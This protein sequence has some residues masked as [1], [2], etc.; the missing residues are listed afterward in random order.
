MKSIRVN[1]NEYL[2]APFWRRFLAGII[3]LIVLFSLLFVPVVNFVLII[4]YAVGKDAFPFLP[5]GSIG[6][7]ICGLKIIS[8]AHG[9]DLKNDYLSSIGRNLFHLL[10]ID[11][12]IALLKKNKRR[13]GDEWVNCDVVLTFKTDLTFENKDRYVDLVNRYEPIY[14]EREEG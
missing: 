2:L 8:R 12:F 9:S 5:G 11:I 4:W 14:L 10:L 7:F 13:I 6:K 3:D 1:K